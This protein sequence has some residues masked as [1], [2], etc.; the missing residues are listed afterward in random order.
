MPTPQTQPSTPPQPPYNLPL[1]REMLDHFHR[2]QMF[3]V[4]EVDVSTQ[5][6]INYY[7]RPVEDIS[8]FVALHRFPSNPTI[9]QETEE[10]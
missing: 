4:I 1:T 6:P 7:F 2:Q 8:N 9:P 10:E 5:T 3:L